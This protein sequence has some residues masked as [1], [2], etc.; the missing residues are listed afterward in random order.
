[1][2]AV[3]QAL[4]QEPIAQLRGDAGPG[5]DEE[6]DCASQLCIA[7]RHSTEK[8]AHAEEVCGEAA[9]QQSSDEALARTLPAEQKNPIKA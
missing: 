3:C 2:F 7:A 4:T 5:I 9:R 8:L 1:V 6:P